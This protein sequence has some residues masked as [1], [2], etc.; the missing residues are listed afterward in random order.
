M[1][2]LRFHC[3]DGGGVSR[4]SRG[5][6]RVDETRCGTLHPASGPAGTV[7]PAN[8]LVFTSTSTLPEP[9]RSEM[10]R[11]CIWGG[12]VARED[13]G[14]VRGARMDMTANS[15]SRAACASGVLQPAVLDNVAHAGASSRGRSLDAEHTRWRSTF[16]VPPPRANATVV[17]CVSGLRSA[18]TPR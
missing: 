5:T 7:S 17:V 13:R 12:A 16:T 6:A 14:P 8:A 11:V 10:T 4:G 18:R 3:A 2:W 15:P 9:A 1:I